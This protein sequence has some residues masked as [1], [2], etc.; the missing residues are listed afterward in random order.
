MNSCHQVAKINTERLQSLWKSAFA[1]QQ[2]KCT[3]GKD[4]ARLKMCTF[5]QISRVLFHVWDRA[6]HLSKGHICHEP[7]YPCKTLGLC[8]FCIGKLSGSFRR[9]EIWQEYKS[10]KSWSINPSNLIRRKRFSKLLIR[11]YWHFNCRGI[12]LICRSEQHIKV[13]HFKY[14]IVFFPIHLLQCS[15]NS[16]LPVPGCSLCEWL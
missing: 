12:L 7:C 3:A 9:T 1:S 6:R 10:A 15:D 11:F 2:Q 5:S 8:F 16:R 14:G 13:I 4:S